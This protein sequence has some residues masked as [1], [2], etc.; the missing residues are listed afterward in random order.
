VDTCPL[1]EWQ[2]WDSASGPHSD[3]FEMKD[4]SNVEQENMPFTR[5]SEA[6]D[7]LMFWSHGIRMS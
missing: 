2:R 3:A 5:W 1:A 7:K 4:Y 6:A